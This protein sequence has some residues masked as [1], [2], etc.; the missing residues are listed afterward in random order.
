[1]MC[2]RWFDY[3]L[4]GSLNRALNVARSPPEA[5]VWLIS[6]P[7]ARAG[8]KKKCGT[9]ETGRAALHEKIALCLTED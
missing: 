6:A 5:P 8:R 9:P 1:M 4:W 3:L 2:A 7:G